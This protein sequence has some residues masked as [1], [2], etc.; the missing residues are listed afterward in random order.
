MSL[1]LPTIIQSVSASQNLDDLAAAMLE[2]PQAELRMEH[3]FCSGPD[4]M[5]VYRRAMHV[6]AGTLVLG[7]A[8]RDACFNIL[9]EGTALIWANGETKQISAPYTFQSEAG[10]QKIGLFL[11]DSTWVNF[12]ATKAS[13][14]DEVEAEII[15][16]CPALD[17]HR[18]I[19]AEMTNTTVKG[20][21]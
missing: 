9:L 6:K 21:S 1:D 17:E 11:T 15:I 18:R 5:N 2:M 3:E 10:V 7:F 14:V 19:I 4:G 8:H 16:P 20:D 12:H 13:T